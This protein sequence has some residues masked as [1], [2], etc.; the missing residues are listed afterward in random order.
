MVKLT[1]AIIKKY[2]ISKKAWAV[3][4]GKKSSSRKTSKKK[5]SK[6]RTNKKS[7]G[8]STMAKKTTSFFGI[9]NDDM[10]K[11]VGSG[12]AGAG[13]ALINKV[14]P[15]LQGNMAQGVAGLLLTNYTH[16]KAKQ[17]GKGI[18]IK[19][20]GDFTEDNIVPTIMN[21]IGGM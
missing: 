20:I 4:R 12:L 13:G 15:Q 11:G 1:K 17:I 21:K 9:G 16:G 3:A 10:W 2:G 5:S 14:V 8:G 19:T 6:K 18:V 7:Y